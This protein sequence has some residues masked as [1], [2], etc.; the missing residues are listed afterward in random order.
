MKEVWSTFDLEIPK[1]KTPDWK[2]LDKHDATA[3]C[4]T[5]R[6]SMGRGL[7]FKAEAKYQ[8]PDKRVYQ[9]GYPGQ[10]YSYDSAAQSI[11]LTNYQFRAPG[12]WFAESYAAFYIRP[13]PRL[14]PQSHPLY[15]TLEDDKL[16]PDS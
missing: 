3:W 10:W 4:K 15:K 2:A 11:A 7:I 16:G 12:E 5:V 1:N 9:Q 14:L 13:A 8:L 6:D